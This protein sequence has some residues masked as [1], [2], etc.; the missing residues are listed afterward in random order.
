VISLKRLIPKASKLPKNTKEGAADQPQVN[1]ISNRLK[2][3]LKK[4][5]IHHHHLE[6]ML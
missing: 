1:K 6:E 4:E 3:S 5:E 2:R